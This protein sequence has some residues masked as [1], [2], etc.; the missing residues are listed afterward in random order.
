MNINS[1]KWQI[2]STGVGGFMITN[3]ETNETRYVSEAPDHNTLAQISE[4]E[5]DKKMAE[6]FYR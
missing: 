3:R 2:R 1:K 6:L 4:Q 5:F